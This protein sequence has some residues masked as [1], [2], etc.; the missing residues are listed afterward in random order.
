MINGKDRIDV[1]KNT[2]V[3][4]SAQIELPTNT[5]K[6]ISADWDFEGKA[7][8]SENGKISSSNQSGTI[9]KLQATHLYSKAGTYFVTLKT[10]AQRE[11]NTKTAFTRINNLSRVRVV[12]N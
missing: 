6:I 10:V 8:F 5:G 12:V 11:G 9:V 4:F 1:K 3:N 2:V 7:T